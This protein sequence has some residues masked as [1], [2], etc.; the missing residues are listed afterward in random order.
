VSQSQAPLGE[1]VDLEITLQG[2]G[3]LTSLHL[4]TAPRDAKFRARICEIQRGREGWRVREPRGSS[5]RL[6]E[7]EGPLTI[8]RRVASI[9]RS[10]E[11]HVRNARPTPSDRGHARGAGRRAIASF[12]NGDAAGRASESLGD[13]ILRRRRRRRCATRHSTA[14][15]RGWSEYRRAAPPAQVGGRAHGAR[16]GASQHRGCGSIADSRPFR[17]KD[18]AALEDVFLE[19]LCTAAPA[20]GARSDPRGGRA[21]RRAHGGALPA[22]LSQARYGSGYPRPRTIERDVRDFVSRRSAA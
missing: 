14:R 19:G 1:S 16:G 12:A 2:N 21:A 3:S 6:P 15:W 10:R 11:G 7:D 18:L 22:R 13:D 17:R 5:G 20:S 8:P 9:L 4:P